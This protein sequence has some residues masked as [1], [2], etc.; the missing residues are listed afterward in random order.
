MEAVITVGAVQYQVD[1][2]FG[3]LETDG[4]SVTGVAEKPTQRVLCNAGIYV[5]SPEALD[6]IKPSSP[7]D[8]T[9]LIENATLEDVSVSAFPIHEYWSDIGSPPDLEKARKAIA[10]N[11]DDG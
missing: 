4:A 6:L 1:I 11:N 7:I 10:Q 8:M 3:V 5:L 9:E 2:P